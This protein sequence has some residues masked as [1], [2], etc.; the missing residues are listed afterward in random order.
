[1]EEEDVKD[2]T[3]SPLPGF[4]NCFVCGKNNPRGLKLNF[5]IHEDG[6]KASFIPDETLVGYE[7]TVHGGIISALLDEA[8]I[9][10][11]YTA[12]KRF[13]ATAELNVRFNKPLHVKETCM[14]EGRMIENKGKLWIVEGKIVDIHGNLF[15]KATGK[16]IPI[17]ET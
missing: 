15:A 10:A 7:N 9:W 12:T 4:P 1:M 17:R 16:V 2:L 5:S 13:G 3:E 6:V 14:V 8:I 11:C